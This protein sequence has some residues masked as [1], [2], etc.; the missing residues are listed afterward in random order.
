MSN[1][2]E[3]YSY[4][5]KTSIPFNKMTLRLSEDSSDY[6]VD[7][8]L[9][10]NSDYDLE[11]N[12]SF[13]R[14]SRFRKIV[15]FAFITYVIYLALD[16]FQLNQHIVGP[17]G[18]IKPYEREFNLTELTDAYLNVLKHSNLAGDWSKKYTS[19][20]HLAGTNYGLVEFTAQ[21]FEEY[22]FESKIEAYNSYINY[23]GTGNTV[24]LL[25]PHK[26]E[27]KVIY[28]PTLVE[29]VLEED[30]TTSGDDLIP[31][32][33]G[34]SANGNVTGPIVFA[35]YGT[36]ED[37]RLLESKNVNV[38]GSV[39]IVRYGKIFRGLKVKFAQEAGAV[40]VIIYSDP[41]DDY[42][43]DGVDAYPEGPG[44]NPSSIQ[45]GSVQFL[46]S[47]PGDPSR[48]TDRSPEALANLTTIP[49]IPSLP[50]SYKEA[51]P[52]LVQ[53]NGYGLDLG[54]EGGIA[55]FSYTTGP[56][57]SQLN[58]FNNNTYEFTDLWNVFGLYEGHE[59]SN[60]VIVSLVII[61]MLG[62]KVVLVI[63]IVVLQLYWKLLEHLMNYLNWVGNH[64]NQS[65]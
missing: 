52:I 62:L 32:F 45:R 2:S 22:G 12:Q 4:R 59:G 31:A 55:N 47:L 35:N 17:F 60:E 57:H 51:Q 40:G 58:I 28:Q 43:P 25:K 20:P 37:F 44:R 16:F 27:F 49:Q 29:D 6:K 65:C 39:V 54:F 11:S 1:C 36:K 53:L 24:K 34:Y 5:L 56:S 7:E 8:K 50:I 9:P 46:S 14:Q 30:P 41:A 26:N 19:E 13:K 48:F 38:K 21:K 63:Q 15:K 61:E 42:T 64:K 23:P 3:R 10:Y 33:H 18:S